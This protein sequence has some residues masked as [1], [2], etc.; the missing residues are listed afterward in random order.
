MLLFFYRALK[1]DSKV[2]HP[3]NQK[4]F[5]YLCLHLSAEMM[6]KWSML[7]IT[8]TKA[9]AG[10]SERKK[11]DPRLKMSRASTG[12]RKHLTQKMWQFQRTLILLLCHSSV[13][14]VREGS[15]FLLGA[16]LMY[17]FVDLYYSP[18]FLALGKS[19]F[20]WSAHMHTLEKLFFPPKWLSTLSHFIWYFD[21]PEGVNISSRFNGRNFNVCVIIAD[22]F[23]I[24]GGKKWIKPIYCILSLKMQNNSIFASSVMCSLQPL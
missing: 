17:I 1:E 6:F 13:S 23:N 5:L 8:W 4:F 3:L 18:C 15:L 21:I 24:L 16:V 7:V 20:E 22:L 14:Q 19:W 10:P 12:S 9:N 11:R 2:F